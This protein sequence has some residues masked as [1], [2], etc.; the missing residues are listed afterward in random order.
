MPVTDISELI[1]QVERGGEGSEAAAQALVEHGPNAVQ[2]IL[3]ALANSKGGSALRLEGALSQVA[4]ADA[5]PEL[6][7]AL[8]TEEIELF[9]SAVRTL[10][11]TRDDRALRPLS[12]YLTDPKNLE[13]QRA[14][15]AEAIGELGRRGGIEPLLS[16]LEKAEQEWL[17]RLL[18]E[19]IIA[20]AKLGNHEHAASLIG[21]F[22]TEDDPPVQVHAAE[23]LS[24]VVA[25]GLFDALVHGLNSDVSEIRRSV[26]RGLSY[27]G[28]TEAIPVLLE[29]ANDAD[30][31]VAND[32]LVRFADIS[33]AA[34]FDPDQVADARAWWESTAGEFHSGICYRLGKPVRVSDI[35]AL[36]E[37][38]RRRA[39]LAE[40]KVITGVDF[41][42]PWYAPAGEVDERAR[43]ESWWTLH[44]HRFAAGKLYKF[45]HRQEL[46][47]ALEPANG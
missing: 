39:A 35:I 4:E 10:G 44:G 37:G 42:A 7:E 24:Y 20:L 32:A 34:F 12:E 47:R 16:V 8:G 17:P 27:L 40:L 28:T 1:E 31:D 45:G 3:A 9:L 26:T 2:P 33:G 19:A 25:P 22:E 23:G 30:P 11:R 5:I 15:A 6:A 43:A 13:G 21:L 18:I 36:L 46:E 38:H 41:S 29:V 14:L